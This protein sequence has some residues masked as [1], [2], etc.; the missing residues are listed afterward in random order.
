MT[1]RRL[2][3]SLVAVVLI[4]F[5]AGCKTREGGGSPD[6]ARPYLGTWRIPESGAIWVFAA[7]NTCSING[8]PGTYTEVNGIIQ[9]AGA[10]SYNVEWQ[11]NEGGERLSLS[12]P[13]K[14]FAAEFERQ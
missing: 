9:L 3:V 1:T 10:A 14:S 7:D 5:V 13:G 11:V 8:K 2:A 6:L 12:R 4:G